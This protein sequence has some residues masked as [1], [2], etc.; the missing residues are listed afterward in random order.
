M[1][2][3][4]AKGWM[5]QSAA[6]L[7]SDQHHAGGILRKNCIR[8]HESEAFDVSLRDHDPIKWIPVDKRHVP[9]REPMLAIDDD[10]AKT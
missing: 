2:I 4:I 6:R 1:M 8:R 5:F 9:D 3:A 7:G 10:L